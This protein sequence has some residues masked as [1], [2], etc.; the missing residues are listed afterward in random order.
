[1]FD[2]FDELIA[3]RL[4]DPEKAAVVA[5]YQ[6]AAP[7]LQANFM[8]MPL[9]SSYHIDGLGKPPRFHETWKP[10]HLLP[11]TMSRVDVVSARG[12]HHTYLGLTVN[13][14]LWL[15][16]RGAV[17]ML[18]WTPS[19]CDPQ[20]VGYARILLRRSNK[21]TEE[22]LKYALL[23]LRTML[24]EC[25][26]QAIPVL[27]G[28]DG[29]ALFVPFGDLPLYADVREWL[30][31]LCRRAVTRHAALLTEAPDEK[32]R[33]DRV[34][35]AVKTNA[36]G[37]FSALP[38]SLAGDPQLGMATP[39]EWNDLGKIDNGKYTAYNSGRRLAND[40]FAE[41]SKAIGMQR[42]SAVR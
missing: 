37:L 32:E 8:N 20:C 19:P 3:S 35:L 39:L 6:R 17:G 13:A 31:G 12:T 16:H 15:A 22:V 41:M 4:A 27:D 7:L 9:V 5:H 24:Q 25:G 10:P 33:G 36:V 40:V 42:F 30:H 21:A 2:D 14:V 28:H 23:A 38:Y 26:L 11:H 34:H 1:M 18:S 29:A